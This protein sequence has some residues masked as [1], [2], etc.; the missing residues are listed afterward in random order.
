MTSETVYG[1]CAAVLVGLGLYGTICH[2]WIMRR[3]LSL[4]LLTAGIFLF[5]G[6]IAKRGG[7]VAAAA[8]TGSDGDPVPQA[9][10]ITGL[11]VAFAASAISVALLK[12]LGEKN[13][14]PPES[15][16][17]HHPPLPTAPGSQAGPLP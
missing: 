17:T 10:V 5:I 13:P 15:E 2:A 4:N 1:L 6:I 7:G 12:R 9:L 11:V 14:S 3:I 8:G 16:A